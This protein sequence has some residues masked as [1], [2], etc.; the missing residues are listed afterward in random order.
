[1]TKTDITFKSGATIT[2]DLKS[3]TLNKNGLGG[4]HSVEWEHGDDRLMRL[5]LDEIVAV[6]WRGNESGKRSKS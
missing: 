5:D 6:V 2:V 3:F 1:M 4:V